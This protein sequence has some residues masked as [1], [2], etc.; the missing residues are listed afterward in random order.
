MAPT[1]VLRT[2]PLVKHR[3]KSGLVDDT[4]LASAMRMHRTTVT[5]VV[6]GEM[7]PGVAFIAGALTAFPDLRFDDLFEIAQA[8]A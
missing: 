2:G 6:A 1:V 7:R 3:K 4:R 8:T 5:R